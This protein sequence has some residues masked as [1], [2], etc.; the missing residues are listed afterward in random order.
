MQSGEGVTGYA[1]G[2]NGSIKLKRSDSGKRSGQFRFPSAAFLAPQCNS[3][4]G[5]PEHR[6]KMRQLSSALC[7]ASGKNLAQVTQSAPPNVAK[8]TMVQRTGNLRGGYKK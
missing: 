2:C 3:L 7:P 4:H 8:L 6:A 5:S 1:C